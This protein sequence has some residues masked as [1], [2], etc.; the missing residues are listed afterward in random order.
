MSNPDII[1]TPLYKLNVEP[2]IYELQNHGFA[3]HIPQT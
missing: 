3:E 2:L 1:A